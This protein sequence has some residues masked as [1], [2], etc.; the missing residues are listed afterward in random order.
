MAYLIKPLTD[1]FVRAFRVTTNGTRGNP[2]SLKTAGK[3]ASFPGR[4]GNL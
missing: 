2:T 3:C 4:V 1:Y